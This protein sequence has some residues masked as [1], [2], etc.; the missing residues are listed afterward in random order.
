MGGRRCTICSHEHV[1][2][3]DRALI[4]GRPIRGIARTFGLGEDAVGR[5]RDHLSRTLVKAHDVDETIR[6]DELLA[7][8]TALQTKAWQLLH[9]AEAQ[10]DP[11]TALMAVRE[12]RGCLELLARLLGELRD[13]PLVTLVAAPEWVAVRGTLLEAL[14]PYPEARTAVASELLALEA[15]ER[16]D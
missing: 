9:E 6:A 8:A 1:G 13:Q 11:R 7:E 5:H 14:A 16:R 15:G 10:S 3:I 2:A 12:V 4:A